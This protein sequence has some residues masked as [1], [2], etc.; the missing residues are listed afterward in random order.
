[1]MEFLK[2]IE[3]STDEMAGHT[4]SELIKII[5]KKVQALKASKLVEVEYMTLLERDREKIQEGVEQGIEQGKIEVAK[6]LLDLL[7]DEVIA[8]RAGIPLE[9]VKILRKQ[10]RANE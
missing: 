6:A 8:E 3:N 5:N 2:Y 1:M 7:E 9:K 10:T 4:K